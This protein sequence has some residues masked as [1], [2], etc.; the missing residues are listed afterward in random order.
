MQCA[1]VQLKRKLDS[2]LAAAK[3]ILLVEFARYQLEAATSSAA[4]AADTVSACAQRFDSEVE[5]LIDATEASDIFKVE[6]LRIA[7]V[8]YTLERE[9]RTAQSLLA[10]RCELLT[11]KTADNAKILQTIEDVFARS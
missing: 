9:K 5:L 6:L 7:K 1:D 10:S 3:A 11:K 2:R 8:T 4:A